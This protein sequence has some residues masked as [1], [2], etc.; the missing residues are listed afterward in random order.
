MSM[1]APSSV[2]LT[3]NYNLKFGLSIPRFAPGNGREQRD[4]IFCMQL[5]TGAG[6][7]AVH[8]DGADGQDPLELRSE[9]PGQVLAECLHVGR[10]DVEL[11][12]AGQIAKGRE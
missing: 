4:L 1:N 12:G 3:A 6:L 10:I 5:S 9:F 2:G 11:R 7:L 8:Q